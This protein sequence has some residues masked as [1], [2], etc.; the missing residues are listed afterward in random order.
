MDRHASLKF[1]SWLERGYEVDK[2][3]HCFHGLGWFLL[4]RWVRLVCNAHAY[5]T[6]PLCCVLCVHTEENRFSLMCTRECVI[7]CARRVGSNTGEDG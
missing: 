6:L 3:K 4:I 1:G 5:V 7:M 2:V